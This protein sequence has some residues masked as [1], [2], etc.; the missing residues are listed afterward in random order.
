MIYFKCDAE[1]IYLNWIYLFTPTWFTVNIF[2]DFVLRSSIFITI[3]SSTYPIYGIT[4]IFFFF[5]CYPFTLASI[6]YSVSYGLIQK[7]NSLIS[8]DSLCYTLN[9][10]KWQENEII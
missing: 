2:S 9:H 8:L 6:N 7:Q 4:K 5:F 1:L 10:A 3:H